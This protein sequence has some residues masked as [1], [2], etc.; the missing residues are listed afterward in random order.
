MRKEEVDQDAGLQV[1]EERVHPHQVEPP[2][3]RIDH[4]LDQ[5]VESESELSLELW[6]VQ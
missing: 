4:T 3:E 1:V 6:N 5:E 2:L